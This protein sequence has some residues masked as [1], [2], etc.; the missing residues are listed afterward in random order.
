MQVYG[1][2]AKVY[3]LFME[4]IDYE[5]WLRHI[6]AVW[7]KY[8]AHPQCVIDLA[9]G[10][11][12]VAISLA[13]EGIEAIGIDISVDMLA[14]ARRK[15]EAQGIGISLFCQDMT[16]FSVSEE[17]DCVLCLCDSLNYLVED[18]ELAKAFSCV[19]QHLTPN[20]LFIFDMN[21]EYKFREVLGEQ[22]YA[23]VLDDAAY[24][25]EN[26]YDEEERVNEYYVCFFLKEKEAY[27]RVEEF[28]YERAYSIEE[29]EACL[30]ASGLKLLEVYNGYQFSES[31]RQAERLVFVAEMK[32]DIEK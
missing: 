9:C 1:R 20:G 30:D 22:T 8:D 4:E 32:G 15:A 19:K 14:E 3:D 16:D 28:H 6:R 11:G 23:A 13:Q 10:T 24:F 31:E 5:S 29:V 7:Q 25:W 17:V 12:T 26:N 21:T 18:G 27:E 2:F